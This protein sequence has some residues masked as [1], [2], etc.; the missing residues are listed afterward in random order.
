MKK[1]STRIAKQTKQKQQIAEVVT[2]L[3]AEVEQL[4]YEQEQYT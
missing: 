3:V 2:T 1:L 4:E